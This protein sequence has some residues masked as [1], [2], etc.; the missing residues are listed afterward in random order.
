M[1]RQWS[2]LHVSARVEKRVRKSAKEQSVEL[3][4]GWVP[5]LSFTFCPKVK[6]FFHANFP[7]PVQDGGIESEWFGQ[8]VMLPKRFRCKEITK[9]CP[10]FVDY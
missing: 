10:L 5:Q 7:A 4:E 6:E 3:T 2:V 9:C 8:C 1:T